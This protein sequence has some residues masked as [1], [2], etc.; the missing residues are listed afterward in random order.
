MLNK[1]LCDKYKD[2]KIAL[3]PASHLSFTA[4]IETDLNDTNVV[5]FF[6][7]DEKKH[8]KKFKGIEVYPSAK[9]EEFQPDVIIIF[10]M[11]YEREIRESFKK[12][13]LNAE[14]LSIGQ[15]I[16]NVL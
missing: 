16:D 12:M 13:E 7:I 6:D 4:V 3:Y 2:A 5:G 14:V 8:G 10:T 1:L 9:L 11:A 15:I